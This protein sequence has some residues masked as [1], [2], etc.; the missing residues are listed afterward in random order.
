MKKIIV[1]IPTKNEQWKVS[2]GGTPSRRNSATV[3][4]NLIRRKILKHL[5]SQPDKKTSVIV[6]DEQGTANETLT[7]PDASYLLY[8]TACFLEDHLLPSYMR[9]LEKEHGKSA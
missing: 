3:V 5:A 6:K 1:T 7:S 2:F 4:Y 8:A 9:A